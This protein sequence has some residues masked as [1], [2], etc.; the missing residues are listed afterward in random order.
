M[1]KFIVPQRMRL[2][3]FTDATYPQ[4]SFA[5]PR[6]LRARDVRVNGKK[7]GENVWLSAGDEVAYYTTPAEEAKPF[8]KEV[9]RDADVLVADKVSGVNTEALAAHLSRTCGALPVHRLDRNTAGL[10]VFALNARAEE[11]LLAA[12]RERAVRK[13]YEAVCVGIFA[14][15]QARLAAYLV[16]DAARAQVRIFARPH[17][18]ALPVE[19][20][21]EVLEERGGLSRVRIVLHTGRTHQLRVQC[22]KHG[23]PIL[24]DATYGDFKANRRLRAASGIGRLFLHCSQTVLH[25]E[26]AGNAADFSAS[27]PL[28]ESFNTMMERRK[29]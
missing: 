22:A 7:T 20:E 3:E 19:T 2:R 25:L 6:L 11:E 28:P 26:M 27:A 9:W 16:K 8:Y 10:L 14:E 23:M 1:Q 24:G 15:K 21:Y 18:G 12:F 4:G 17:A 5:L 29:D 13:E